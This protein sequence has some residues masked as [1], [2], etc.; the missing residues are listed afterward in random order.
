MCLLGLARAQSHWVKRSEVDLRHW[1]TH[2]SNPLGS[3][4]ASR[5]PS[6]LSSSW[7]SSQ[8]RPGLALGHVLAEPH[9]ILRISWP[10][11]CDSLSLERR[12]VAKVGE[13]FWAPSSIHFV[14]FTL[15]GVGVCAKVV[16][17]WEE[18]E[19]KKM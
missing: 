2:K 11:E 4:R 1:L 6:I 15:L 8:V 14:F 16:T 17:Y 3:A 7:N 18:E 13:F 9:D 10:V 5:G 19:G 12:A